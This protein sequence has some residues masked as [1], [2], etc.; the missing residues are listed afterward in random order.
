MQVIALAEKRDY[1]GVDVLDS[2]YE[3]DMTFIGF[4][5]FLDPPKKGVANTINKLRKIYLR[6]GR[7]YV[8]FK[9]RK[10]TC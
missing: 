2:S 4:I 9:N 10:S 7:F 1:P 3:R 5:G 8:D 6:K